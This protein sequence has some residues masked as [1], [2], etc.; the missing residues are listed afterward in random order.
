MRHK[1]VYIAHPIGG[2]VDNNLRK[3]EAIVR[4]ICLKTDD[5]I[6]VAPYHLL[7]HAL[8]DNSISER[9]IGMEI[10]MAYLKFNKVTEVWLYGNRISQGMKTEI[11]LAVSLGIKVVPQTFALQKFYKK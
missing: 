11:E 6:P 1:V 5:I 2:D 7:C 3:V 10:S 4:E 9:A 8:D